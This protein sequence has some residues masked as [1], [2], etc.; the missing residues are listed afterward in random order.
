MRKAQRLAI[1]RQ[2]LSQQPLS[3]QQR[4]TVRVLAFL[5]T[6][7]TGASVVFRCVGFYRASKTVAAMNFSEIQS[8]QEVRRVLV[9][10]TQ[11]LA[12]AGDMLGLGNVVL[13]VGGA[14]LTYA[15]TRG[16]FREPWFFWTTLAFSMFFILQPYLGTFFGLWWFWLLFWDRQ[17]FSVKQAIFVAK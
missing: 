9:G 16:R 17:Q 6:L 8:E 4:Q 14:M 7:L 13:L 12:Q 15:W 2:L 10:V 1:Q 5:G 11:G 3:Q